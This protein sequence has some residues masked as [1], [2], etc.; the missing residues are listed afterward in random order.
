MLGELIY[1]TCLQ[2]MN[3]ISAA[4]VRYSYIH[5]EVSKKNKPTHTKQ[6]LLPQLKEVTDKA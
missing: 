5:S 6:K 3:S 4:Y 2:E 1:S